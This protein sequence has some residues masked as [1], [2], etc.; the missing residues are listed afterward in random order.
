MEGKV[1]HAGNLDE[2]DHS[3]VEYVSMRKMEEWVDE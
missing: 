1:Q 2:R 3:I